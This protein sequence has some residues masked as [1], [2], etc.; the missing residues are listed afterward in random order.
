MPY[1]TRA[2]HPGDRT[3]KGVSAESDT[4]A[5]YVAIV[6]VVEAGDTEIDEATYNSKLAANVVH[7]SAVL[8]E[9]KQ[10]DFKEQAI[11]AVKAM[12]PD[13]FTDPDLRDA[14]ILLR[15]AALGERQPREYTVIKT[16]GVKP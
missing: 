4:G 7:N 10:P 16:K 1:V 11:A 15:D 12:D 6:P 14:F 8:P 13:V 5:N 2:L 3:A 9:V